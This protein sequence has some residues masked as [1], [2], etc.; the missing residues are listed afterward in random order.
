MRSPASPVF[1]ALGVILPFAL[2]IVGAATW[3]ESE[4]DRRR[5]RR[6]I[7]GLLLALLSTGCASKVATVTPEPPRIDRL[8]CGGKSC[9]ITTSGRAT[10]VWVSE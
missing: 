9:S 5:R 7:A 10:I 3:I 2:T 6:Q 8:E 4:V 1:V